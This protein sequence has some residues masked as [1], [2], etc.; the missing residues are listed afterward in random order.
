MLGHVTPKTAGTYEADKAILVRT[1][2]SGEQGVCTGR[3]NWKLRLEKGMVGENSGRLSACVVVVWHKS[4]YKTNGLNVC[5][6]ECL[7]CQTCG[8][9]SCS[10]RSRKLNLFMAAVSHFIM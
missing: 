9:V 2:C 3:L 6:C 4:S 5:V 10:Q 8:S 7:M 1:G